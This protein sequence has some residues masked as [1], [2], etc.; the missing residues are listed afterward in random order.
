MKG[1][2]SCSSEG[3]AILFYCY[4]KGDPFQGPRVGSNT[5]K[6]IVWEDTRAD[7][8]RD[9]IGKGCL[10]REQAGKLGVLTTG[11]SVL[12]CSVLSDCATPWAV[13]GQASLSVEVLQ[14]TIL[15]WVTKPSSRESSQPRNQTQV[16][17]IAGGFFTV[18]A[19][20]EALTT[21][22]PEKAL[23]AFSRTFHP[24]LMRVERVM[25]RRR[26]FTE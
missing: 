2:I 25:G 11:I 15:E 24:G 10:G 5:Q 23:L 1:T 18:W 9:Y 22:P 6:W 14:A 7:K 17:H 21:G 19:T 16:S 8:A 3:G 20:R 12:S 4:R 26:D 13:A